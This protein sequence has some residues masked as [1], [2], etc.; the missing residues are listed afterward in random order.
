ML[1]MVGKTPSPNPTTPE[2]LQSVAILKN[3]VARSL[4][5]PRFRDVEVNLHGSPDRTLQAECCMLGSSIK[6]G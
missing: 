6:N 3:I 5:A 1:P 2:R 4:L